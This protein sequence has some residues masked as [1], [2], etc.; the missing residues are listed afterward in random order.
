MILKNLLYVVLLGGWF[1]IQAQEG[2]I[3]MTKNGTTR[4]LK[5]GKR[6]KVKTLSG[7]KLIGQF[8]IHDKNTIMIKGQKIRLDAIFLIKRKSRLAGIVGTYLIIAGAFAFPIGLAAALSSEG[9]GSA[10]GGISLATG[11]YALG[12]GFLLNDFHANHKHPKWSYKIVLN[13]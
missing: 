3:E 10:I 1:A 9:I 4:T 5:E 12:A 6:I 13:D 2:R 11:I 7:E 8:I